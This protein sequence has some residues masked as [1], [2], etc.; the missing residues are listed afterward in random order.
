VSRVRPSRQNRSRRRRA[1]GLTAFIGGLLVILVAVAVVTGPSLLSG[2]A[3]SGDPAPSP[4]PTPE[5]VHEPQN[6]DAYIEADVGFPTTLNPLLA[7]SSSE[8]VVASLLFRGLLQ[9]DTHGDP[10]PDLA[11]GWSVTEDGLRYEVQLAE[12]LRWH[13]GESFGVDDVLF[14]VSLVQ[15]AEFPGDPSLSRFWRSITAS[16]VDE[17]T[18]AFDLMEPYASFPNY[19][20]LPVLPKHVFRGILPSDLLDPAVAW[21]A[22]GTG[23]YALDGIDP[24]D[25]ELRFVAAKSS[26]ID[27]NIEE[28]IIRYF[29]NREDALDA[30]RDGSVDGVAYVPLDA[31]EDSDSLP[32]GSRVYAPSLPGYT[33]LYFNVRHPLFRDAESRRAIEYAINRDEIIERVFAGHAT[34]GSSPIPRMLSAH[35]PGNHAEYDP[36]RARDLLEEAGWRLAE[37]EQTRQRDGER[38]TM[39]LLLNGDDPQRMALARVIRE[40]LAEVGV[41]VDIQPMSGGEVGQALAARQFASAIYGWR[42][43]NGD[44]DCFQMWHSSQADSGMNFS[45]FAHSE[46]D[47]LLVAARHAVNLET[48]NQ[49]YAEFQAIFAEQVPAVVLF[50]PR[51]HFAVSAR[52]HGAEPEPLV[53]PGNRVRQI[54]KW[55]IRETP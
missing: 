9:T 48:R 30:F 27:A 22:I 40:Q 43:E 46:V 33:A 39:P 36:D 41:A 4:E 6:A 21:N 54:P 19:L 45:G 52:V 1:A 12:D 38:F 32:P 10:Q 44:P 26:G 31:L 35:S 51:Y 13:D 14:T 34:S 23:P 53:N 20:T 17:A 29:D 5:E 15:D 2:E 25:R 18:I 24:E 28:V 16:Q 47:E 8:R 42:T 7:E 50:Y 55:Y 49:H 11:S 3:D 37:G